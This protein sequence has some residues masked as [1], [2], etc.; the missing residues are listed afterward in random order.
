MGPASSTHTIPSFCIN[1]VKHQLAVGNTVTRSQLK[2][3]LKNHFEN[4]P[5]QYGTTKEGTQASWESVDGTFRSMFAAMKNNS[6]GAKALVGFL[7]VVNVDGVDYIFDTENTFEKAQLGLSLKRQ[8]EGEDQKYLDIHTETQFNLCAIA[9][10][11]GY[12]IFV[13]FKNR[14]S[15]TSTGFTIAQVFSEQLVE[16]F[17]GMTSISR[18]IDVIFL[19]EKEGSL[20]P[21]RTYEIENSTGVISGFGRIKSLPVHGVVVDTTG[22]YKTKY[23]N[24]LNESFTE[25]KDK[26]KYA[27]S[28]DVFKLSEMLEDLEDDKVLDNEE[29]KKLILKKI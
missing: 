5:W 8:Y 3:A 19:E 2:N 23:D 24:Y 15:K 22:K 1:W 11:A 9:K 26:V 17:V 20:L 25:L 28:K 4:C 10:S 18:E 6:G 27:T 16:N 21:V 12:K 14:N 7:K 29:V 13:P